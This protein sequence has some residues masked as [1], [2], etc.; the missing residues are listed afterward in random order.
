VLKEANGSCE[1]DRTGMPVG[2]DSALDVTP[3]AKPRRTAKRRRK[4]DQPAA[5]HTPPARPAT[6]RC[7]LAGADWL[8]VYIPRPHKAR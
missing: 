6:E 3:P 2:R 7:H 1:V 8:S 5:V 4:A